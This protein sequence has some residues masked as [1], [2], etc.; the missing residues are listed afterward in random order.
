MS[1][2]VA[3][4]TLRKMFA[5]NNTRLAFSGL[6]FLV[7][8][9]MLHAYVLISGTVSSFKTNQQRIPLKT[10]TVNGQPVNFQ[11]MVYVPAGS[12]IMG[13]NLKASN[14]SAQPAH[15]VTLKGYW[16]SKY[17]VT[18]REYAKFIKATGYP[19]PPNWQHGHYPKGQ[20]DYP[21]TD[22]SF[23]DA[24]AY[25][26]WDHVSLPTEAQWEKAARGPYGRIYPWGNTWKHHMANIEYSVG[27]TT[28]VGIYP[29][30][31]SYYGLYDMS[32]NVW[33]WTSSNYGP[34]PG[35]SPNYWTFHKWKGYKVVRGGSYRSDWM[36]ARSYQRNA[37][38]PGTR[39]SYIGFRVVL[40]QNRQHHAD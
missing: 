11:S 13:T 40:N 4:G 23:Y 3:Q 12:F 37:E 6:F 22:V 31:V 1:Q 20:G 18:D 7:I 35:A 39:L 14:A 10:P 25:C 8:G 32:G 24:T 9:I 30:G 27:S 29:A 34:Y 26:K 15:K 36:S 38:K 5:Q 33:E 19:A 17:L 21:V 2:R 16:I 28:P